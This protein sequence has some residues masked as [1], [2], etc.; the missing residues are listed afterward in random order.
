MMQCLIQHSFDINEHESL[1]SADV[2]RTYCKLLYVSRNVWQGLTE[3]VVLPESNS[4]D[5]ALC[6]LAA[7]VDFDGQSEILIGTYGQVHYTMYIVMTVLQVNQGRIAVSQFP[8]AVFLQLLWKRTIRDIWTCALLYFFLSTPADRK[9][10]D[11]SVT[12]CVCFVCLYGYGFL[13]RG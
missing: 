7:D 10:V 12:V 3:L 13:Q 1:F 9:G 8:T 2:F 11:I 4:Y 6:C 5:S